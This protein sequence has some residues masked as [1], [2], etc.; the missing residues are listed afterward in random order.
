[1]TVLPWLRVDGR[2]LVDESGHPVRLYGV[3]MGGWMNMENFIT[4]YPGNEENIRRILLDRMGQ[5]P[6]DA[7]FEAFYAD[8]ISE[9][10]A[11]HLASLGLNSVR[12]PFNYRHFES[13]A[14]PFELREQGFEMLDRV[15]DLFARHGI[16]SILDLHAAPGRQNRQ[17]HSD[18]P[19][20]LAEFWQHPH[21][22]DRAIHLW[23]ALADRYRDRPE[24]AGYNPLNEPAAELGEAL[25]EFYDQVAAVI[26]AVDPRHI[27]FLDGNKQS[28]DFSIFA[29]RNEP[30]PNTVYT[31]HDY[32]LPGISREAQYPGSTKGEHYDRARLEETFLKRTA[33]MRE[34]G[35]PIWV[36]EFGPF[37]PPEKPE[38][39]W[40]YQLLHDQLEIYDEHEASWALWTFKDVGL[41]GLLYAREDSAYM[42]QI[43]PAHQ[44]KEQLGTDY[45][46]GS[47]VG[48]SHLLQ[49]IKEL[50][51][52]EFPDFHPYPW[53][54]DRHIGLLVRNILLA[55]PLAERF[56][57]LFRGVSPEQARALAG[58]FR[59]DQCQERSELSKIIREHT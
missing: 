2:H 3:G 15:I 58:S 33:Y 21:F 42:Q 1:M 49:P 40:R 50:F 38:E 13:D 45:W 54:Q 8:F 46:G 32:A 22:Q 31:A 19:G 24:V 18:N 12:I 48:V 7:F 37:Y 55:E 57:D 29:Q 27:L 23:E 56:G 28:T 41:Q 51:V 5:E 30:L 4:G 9:D 14:R 25:A 52:R 39:I 35:T 43:R 10:D 17:W 53:G 11:A 16:Y 59:F 47:E 44:L 20:H 26:R 34:T 36:G 6:Y